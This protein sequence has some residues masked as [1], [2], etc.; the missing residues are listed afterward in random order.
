MTNY[1]IRMLQARCAALGFWPG[2]I[3]GKYGP[4][5]R[6]AEAEARAAQKRRGRPLIHASGLS[7]VHWHWTGG[8]HK[9]NRDDKRPYHVL[10]EGSGAMIRLA[11]LTDY[12]P[13]T[14]KAN[15]GAVGLSLC[16][17]FEAR[18]RPFQSGP[19]PITA[20]QVDALVRETAEICKA[21]D[22]PVSQWSTLSHAEIQPTL[23]IK[24][25]LKWDY[26]W[27]P[28]MSRPGDPIEV[29][30]MLRDMLRAK[31]RAMA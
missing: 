1:E 5:T 8:H 11:A 15:S 9:P 28:G 22:I 19:E 23:G 21:Y 30:N 14:L 2:P 25:R 12:R 29:G 7:R 3:D 24:Q 13:H 17:M 16:G 31:L 4:R 27:L 10:F 6:A 20:A 26:T 18:E